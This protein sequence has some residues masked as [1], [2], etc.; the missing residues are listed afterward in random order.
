MTV[1]GLNFGVSNLGYAQSLS[2]NGTI[3][4]TTW[5]SDSTFTT[6]VLSGTGGGKSL[7][8]NVSSQ[9]STFPAIF[10]NARP[11]I[12]SSSV[13]VV[14]TTGG[15]QAVLIQGANFGTRDSSRGMDC[16]YNNSMDLR[17][18]TA[19]KSRTRYRGGFEYSCGG[20]W[21]RRNQFRGPLLCRTSCHTCP[22]NHAPNNRGLHA[23]YLWQQL[24]RR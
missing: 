12:T 22:S 19:R 1:L 9:E 3:L 7:T 21:T 24:R 10:S 11:L 6:R 14:P 17:Y 5:T 8:C 13:S 4:E 15:G 18:G 16:L 23:N 2:N 20:G